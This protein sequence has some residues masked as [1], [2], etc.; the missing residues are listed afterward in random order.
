[1]KRLVL[2]I[3]AMLVAATA[4]AQSNRAPDN[5]RTFKMFAGADTDS[6]VQVSPW[7]PVFGARR[8][9]LRTYTSHIG[10]GANA[11]STKSDSLESFTVQF[12]DSVGG[13]LVGPDGPYSIGADSIVV[14]ITAVGDST[15]K[16]ITVNAYPINKILRAPAN[17]SGIYTYIIPWVQSQTKAGEPQGFIG[18]RLMRVRA[19]P[20]RRHTAGTSQCGAA[21]CCAPGCGNRVNGLRRLT[22]YADVYYA[23]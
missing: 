14:P 13:L 4:F 3:L 12:S 15:F 16:G 8:I 11:D 7:I 19:T 22:Q 2:M 6:N 17:G 20:L 23:P 5:Y 10:F 1:M 21:G 9:I 18:A